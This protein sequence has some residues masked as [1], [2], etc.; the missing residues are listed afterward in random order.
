MYQAV[1]KKLNVYFIPPQLHLR[2]DIWSEVGI[3]LSALLSGSF[4]LRR[5]HTTVPTNM[6]R[7]SLDQ[8]CQA[9]T[10]KELL[11]GTYSAL[12]ART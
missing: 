12:C 1:S 9:K 8:V 4:A 5:F 11:H 6:S 7:M 3:H 10:T 2:L